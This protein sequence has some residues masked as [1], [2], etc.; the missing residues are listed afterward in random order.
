MQLQDIATRLGCELQGDGA[1]EIHGVA[2]I[3]SAEPGT[4]TFI[5]NPRYRSYLHT[6]RASAIILARSEAPV[7]IPSLRTAD[8]Y[9]AFAG[10]LEIFYAPP[11][12][13]SVG[14]HP[15]A[16]VADSA[17]LGRDVT[18]GPYAV[19]GAGV[20]I[21]DG[22]HIDAHVV[23][24][25]EVRIGDTFRA[26]ANVTVRERVQI[27]DRVIL[28]SGSVIGGDGFGYI[29]GPDGWPRKITQAGTVVLEDDVEI[30]ENTT[31]DRA[32]V[33]ATIVH[34]GAKLDNLVMIA[35]GCS[36]GQ[37]S[38]LVGQVGLSG[39]THV[40]QYVRMGGQVGAAG[41]LTI[42]DGAQIAAQSGISNDIPAGA[43]VG[44]WPP[45]EIHL[46]RRM[47]AALPRVPELLKRVRRLEAWRDSRSASS[48]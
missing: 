43:I 41:H 19:I 38:M 14:I 35:H 48:P 36:I 40:G 7:E 45:I 10:A 2:P 5:A 32:A 22:A 20:V 31:V 15:T 26:Y 9:L 39:S 29:A 47:L 34:R 24:Y 30:G 1:V 44:G 3:E 42:G 23:I 18:L 13:L 11:P 6:T 28:H 37:G 21:G 4:L 12:P 8:P 46:W 25:P 33:G 16:V 27:G 17:Q